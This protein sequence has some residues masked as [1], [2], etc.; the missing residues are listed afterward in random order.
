[1]PRL[2][3]H[4]Q[5]AKLSKK[6]FCWEE[7]FVVIPGDGVAGDDDVAVNLVAPAVPSGL[8]AAGEQFQIGAVWQPLNDG[9]LFFRLVTVF[10]LR[11]E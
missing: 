10:L 3:I 5:I 7:N 2:D 11:R 4:E 1:M 6:L 8:A 9:E